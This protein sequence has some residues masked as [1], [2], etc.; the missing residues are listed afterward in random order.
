MRRFWP[1]WITITAAEAIWVASAVW[2]VAGPRRQKTTKHAVNLIPMWRQVGTPCL[3]LSPP[4]LAE[5]SAG[6][7]WLALPL[8]RK[9]NV[10][11]GMGAL[12]MLDGVDPPI[13]VDADRAS[14]SE[15]LAEA[16]RVLKDAAL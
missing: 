10:A 5:T 3:N 1:I 13:V 14:L 2:Q 9:L 7:H 4:R 15:M 16:S 11:L 6:S 12:V 8:Y